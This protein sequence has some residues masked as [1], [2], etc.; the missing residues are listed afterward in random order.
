RGVDQVD[1]PAAGDTGGVDQDVDAAEALLRIGDRRADRA[2]VAHVTRVEMRARHVIDG[3]LPSLVALAS[4][5]EPRH[6]RSLLGEAQR[7]SGTD[8]GRG[9]GDECDLALQSAHRRSFAVG[10]WNITKT[11]KY[12]NTKR[13]SG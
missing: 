3:V 2:V 10:V 9:T 1:R 6:N 11:R 4:E 13:S 7:A 5:I 8:A 12:E